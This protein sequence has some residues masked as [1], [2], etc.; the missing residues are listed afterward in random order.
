MCAWCH[1]NVIQSR[2]RI[3]LSGLSP[4]RFDFSAK[5]R[6]ISRSHFDLVLS[7]KDRERSWILELGRK[8][9]F[10]QSNTFYWTLEAEQHNKC[11]TQS[12]WFLSSV[13]TAQSLCNHDDD[14]WDDSF[15][16]LGLFW[17]PIANQPSRFAWNR[18][19]FSTEIP[20]SCKNVQTQAKRNIWSPTDTS[21][22]YL[23][24]TNI[25]YYYLLHFWGLFGIHWVVLACRLLLSCD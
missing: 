6:R 19:G 1:S 25:N 9:R 13:S 3:R 24:A 11:C 20:T 21:P 5:N 10:N 4:W 17:W 7:R 16:S 8:S 23:V 14:Q 12:S 15:P 18:L 22:Q 2:G